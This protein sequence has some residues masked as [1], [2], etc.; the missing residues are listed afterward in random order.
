MQHSIHL[1]KLHPSRQLSAYT[2]ILT[3]SC[4]KQH[5]SL[6]QDLVISGVTAQT[7]CTLDYCI[8]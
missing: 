6:L 7:S 3:L 4:A 8:R 1:T 5:R 2:L